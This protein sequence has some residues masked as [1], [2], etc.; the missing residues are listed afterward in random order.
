MGQHRSFCFAFRPPAEEDY[1]HIVDPALFK[2][3]PLEQ[4][5]GQHFGLKQRHQ[6]LNHADSRA[7]SLQIDDIELL[8]KSIRIHPF[9][10]EGVKKIRSGIHHRHLTRF[11]RFLYSFSLFAKIEMDQRFA[12]HQCRQ[13]DRHIVDTGRQKYSH[14][15]AGN[16]A[17]PP[18]KQHCLCKHC[19]VAQFRPSPLGDTVASGTLACR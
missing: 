9:C 16:P 5:A 4:Q 2:A 10:F 8:E 11:D 18:G 17:Q 19:R 3:E 7:H 15:F 6:L 13:C 1:R 14:T 12:C